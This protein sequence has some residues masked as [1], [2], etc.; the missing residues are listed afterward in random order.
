METQ[1]H[2]VLRS[3]TR[4]RIAFWRRWSRTQYDYF[5][6]NHLDI[7]NAVQSALYPTVK[8]FSLKGECGRIWKLTND[9]QLQLRLRMGSP[10]PLLHRR[11][12]WGVYARIT[13]SCIQTRTRVNINRCLTIYTG[14]GNRMGEIPTVPTDGSVKENG[15]HSWQTA[16]FVPNICAVVTH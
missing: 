12:R 14:D 2:G 7:D 16:C 3:L 15:T 6:T 9:S 11:Q 10:L 8:S 1:T 5:C 13:S 4:I